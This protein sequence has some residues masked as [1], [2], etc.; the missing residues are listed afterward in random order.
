MKGT[1]QGAGE[2]RWRLRVFVGREGGKV[3][4]VNRNFNGNKRQ[5]QGALA[6]LVADI[7]RQQVATRL[8]GTLGELIDDWLDDISPRRSAYTIQEYRR[9][10]SK[11]IK[12][13]L[14]RTRVDRLTPRQLDDFYRS[15]ERDGL[16]GSSIHQHHSILHASLKRA[17]K[18]GL[19]ATNPADRATAPRPARSS[20]AAPAVA[21]VQKLIA[22]ADD[23]GDNVLATAIALGAMTGARRGELCALRWSDLNRDRGV[24]RIARSL[25]VV[26]AKPNEGPTKTHQRRDIA[27]DPALAS[28]LAARREQQERFAA[29]AGLDLVDDPFVLSRCS[30]GSAPCLPDGLS[31][32]YARLVKRLGIVTH[33]HE[34]RHF[35]A[36]AAIAEGIDVRTVAGRLGHADPSLTL[37]VYAHALEARDGQLAGILGTTVLGPVHHGPEPD[38]A[39]PPAPAELEGAR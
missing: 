7:E 25:T 2:G 28:L 16:S 5:A 31:N 10:V 39:D 12:P 17:V 4:H 24:L 13:A 6:K 38:Q 8:A 27:I 34:L 18:W 36:T 19:L 29:L 11:T 9:I 33:F 22:A 1:L 35:S 37:R 26:A 32:A 30:D 14:G 3:R 21:D 23:D 20:A 15:L